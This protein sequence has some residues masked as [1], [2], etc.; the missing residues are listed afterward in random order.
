MSSIIAKALK[1]VNVENLNGQDRPLMYLPIEIM[2]KNVAISIEDD[3][4]GNK[5]HKYE[6][7]KDRKKIVANLSVT[8]AMIDGDEYT[9][10]L[11]EVQND[12]DFTIEGKDHTLLAGK[13]K[14]M[15]KPV[16]Y[17]LAS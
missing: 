14:L 3:N 13:Q 11:G 2:Q 4:Y 6:F 12:T 15:L 16:D 5:V 9:V 17:K 8:P 7:I 1:Q 10:V